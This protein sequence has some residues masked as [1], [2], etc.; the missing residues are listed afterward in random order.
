MSIIHDNCSII[1][2]LVG[3]IRPTFLSTRVQTSGKLK[4]IAP[5]SM[6]HEQWQQERQLRED[7]E[8]RLID[9][10]NVIEAMLTKFA[11][12]QKMYNQERR[13]ME[14]AAKRNAN[15]DVHTDAALAMPIDDRDVWESASVML[16]A[17]AYE[18]RR[19]NLPAIS[20]CRRYGNSPSR[21]VAHSVWSER[22]H[23]TRQRYLPESVYYNAKL[24]DD[25]EHLQPLWC[26]CRQ[27]L[28]SATMNQLP[29]FSS[30]DNIQTI[31]MY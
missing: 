11:E 18:S 25:E 4:M 6:L 12:M 14:E 13:Q 19:A 28:F 10:S 16:E 3:S 5:N 9:V 30:E 7:A 24:T 8:K 20:V 23:R 26:D 27:V 21:S 15:Q 17:P 29:K 2:L 22:S 1:L 31:E